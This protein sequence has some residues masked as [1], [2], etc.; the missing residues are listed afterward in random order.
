[1]NITEF[2][3]LKRQISIINN[4][5]IPHVDLS[6]GHYGF[7]ATVTDK[8]PV[9]GDG[10]PT[11]RLHYI[12]DGY[13]TL[14]VGEKTYKLRKNQCF[15]LR[16]D[17][18]I[19]YQTDSVHPA[20]FYWVSFTGQNVFYYLEKM[21]FSNNCFFFSI[22]TKFQ[23]KLHTAFFNNFSSSAETDNL[24]DLIF[25]ENF[26]K[27]VQILSLSSDTHPLKKAKE[28]K[29][30]IEHAI[31]II[32]NSY[33]NPHLSIK[34]VAKELFLH[35]NYFSKIFK[36]DTGLT[37]SSYLSRFRI[38]MSLALIQEGNTSITK[39]AYAVGFLDPL[40]FSKV[41]KKYNLCTPSE[42]I[43]KTKQKDK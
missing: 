17:M 6:I 3:S 28:N 4:F 13:L 34:D 14:R 2:E 33:S 1:M 23:S 10:Y 16:P 41:F 38:E 18:D 9:T 19:S 12:I 25:F 20:S 15:Y 22:P 43:A 35:E 5:T 40:Y 27:I 8:L 32:N 21:G 7:E 30:Y 24:K 37:F 42:H 11:Y 36:V 26:M 29:N 39:I 31:E